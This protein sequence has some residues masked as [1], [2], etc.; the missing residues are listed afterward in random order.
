MRHYP[1]RYTAP[2]TEAPDAGQV[3][4]ILQQAVTV[5]D[6]ALQAIADRDASRTVERLRRLEEIAVHARYVV[7]ATR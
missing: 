7:L 4:A 2:K 1:P 3:P 5:I 6:E